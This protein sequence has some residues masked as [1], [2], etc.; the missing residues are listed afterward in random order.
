MKEFDLIVTSFITPYGS[1]CYITMPFGLKNAGVT[2][3]RCMQ[4]CIIDKIH[5][6]DQPDQVER[7]KPTIT[8]YVDDIVVKTVQASD[9]I[10]N[11]TATFTNLQ[12]FSVKLNPEKY[13]L[14]FRRGSCSDTSCTSAASQPT[15]KKS[16]P[17]PIWVPYAMS[18]V[19]KGSPA[20]WLP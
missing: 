18:R 10:A 3:Q 6:P 4:R 13:V 20:V 14:E 17:S 11:L 2:Y 5:S 1:Y 16:W 12:L 8:I 9:L 15:P 7:P 19:C